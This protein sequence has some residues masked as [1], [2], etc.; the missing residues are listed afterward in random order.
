MD[1]VVIFI[2]SSES[3]SARRLKCYGRERV[4]FRTD[5]ILY[6]IVSECIV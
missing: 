5:T 2:V 1:C 3:E 4:G 6:Y